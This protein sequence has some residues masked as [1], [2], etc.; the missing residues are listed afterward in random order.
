MKSKILAAI[1]S[2]ADPIG[3]T[4]I[5][6]SASFCRRVYLKV[7]LITLLDKLDNAKISQ[8]TEKDI[9]ADISLLQF[10]A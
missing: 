10:S 4:L 5:A 8:S 9:Q 2:P 3:S 1:L 6:E 7:S